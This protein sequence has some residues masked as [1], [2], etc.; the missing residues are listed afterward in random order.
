MGSLHPTW[1]HPKLSLGASHMSY[2]S[3]GGTTV[4]HMGVCLHDDS[5]REMDKQTPTYNSSPVMRDVPGMLSVAYPV[6]LCARVLEQSCGMASWRTGLTSSVTLDR[7]FPS[8][9]LCPVE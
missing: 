4:N 8:V 6:C 2:L 1:D 7:F 9:P 5:L 3:L